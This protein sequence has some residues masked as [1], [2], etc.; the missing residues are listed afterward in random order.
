MKKSYKFLC[1]TIATAAALA[2]CDPIE[3]KDLRNDYENAGTPLTASELTSKLSVTQLPNKSD[4]VE[5]DQYIIVKNNAPEVGGMWILQKDG[6]TVAKT[7]SNNDTIIAGSN[8]QYTLVYQ[9]ISANKVVTS[10]VFNLTVTNVFDEYDNL[11]TGAKDKTDATAKKTWKFRRIVNG[12]TVG[13]A[14]NGAHGA[15]KY[16]SAGYTPESIAGVAWWGTIGDNEMGDHIKQR[17]V[18]AYDGS[19][20]TIYGDNGETLS[21]GVFS[22][23]HD[24]VET[25]VLGW[26]NTSVTVMGSAYWNES[27]G[28]SSP[29]YC[30]YYILTLT[31]KYMTL[32]NPS[33]SPGDDWSSY[34]WYVYYE[35]E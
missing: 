3:D 27:V 23:N 21:E 19:K 32:Y 11:L 8:G 13:Y 24:E 30:K 22:Y 15:W 14:H 10:N 6:V 16:T 26:L 28:S 18:F 12:S 17:M 35:A 25:G 4:R 34:G 31:D 5:G 1:L 7:A 2:S 29:W 33:Q 20:I 9:G